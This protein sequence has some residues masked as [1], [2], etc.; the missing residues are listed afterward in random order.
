MNRWEL[1][2]KIVI[3]ALKDPAFKRK[4]ISQPKETVLEFL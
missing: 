3:K 1:E 2:Q 4:L